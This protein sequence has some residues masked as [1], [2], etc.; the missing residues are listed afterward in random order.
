MKHGKNLERSKDVCADKT[1][2]SGLMGSQR[3]AKIDFH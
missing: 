3:E 2:S 1:E